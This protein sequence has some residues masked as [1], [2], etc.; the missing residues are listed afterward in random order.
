LVVEEMRTVW[1]FGDS[2]S[3]DFEN[4]RIGNFELYKDLKGSYPKSWGKLISEELGCDYKNFAQGGW[5]N[6]S[7]LQS[8]CENITEIKPNDIVFVGWAPEPRIRI[9]DE[10]GKWRSFNVMSQIDWGGI[11]SDCILD[12]LLN[13]VTG[14]HRESNKGVEE[15]RIAWENMIKFTMKDMILHIWRWS[16]IIDRGYQT[17]QEES[18]GNIEDTHWSE[19]GH[20]SYFKDLIKELNL[21]NKL[22]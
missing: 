12:L 20:V 14:E 3:V 8:F 17:I 7:I 18:D 10:N 9:T 4:N 6:Y 15:E 11:S 5:D 1:V 16:N 13:R 2:F 19:N 22:I 21:M